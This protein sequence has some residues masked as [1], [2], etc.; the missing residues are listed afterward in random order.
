MG[1]IIKLPEDVANRIAA[2]EVVERP[3]SV[4]KELLENS[5][6][7]DASYIEIVLS[8]GGKNLVLV[9]DDGYGM[10]PDD[11]FLALERHATSKIRCSDDLT[12]I[13]TL[14]FRGEALPSIASVSKLDIISRQRGSDTAFRILVD[15][16][17]IVEQGNVSAQF[18]T[19]VSVK[20]LFAKLPA[21]KRFLKSDTTELS[22]CNAVI[23]RL[24]IA[25]PQTAF[26]VESDGQ[27]SLY[28]TA[29]GTYRERIEQIFGSELLQKCR[30]I[31]YE[32]GEYSV[33]GFV[34]DR[35]LHRSRASDEY[36]FL[37]SRPIR[38]RLI[39]AA[40]HRA[41]SGLLPPRRYPIA[42]IFLQAPPELVDVNVH[43]AKLEVRFRREEAVFG[44]IHRA[45]V[46]AIGSVPSPARTTQPL[47]LS[48]LE[49]TQQTRIDFP[50]PNRPSPGK[51][52]RQPSLMERELA[53]VIDSIGTAAASEIQ[54]DEHTPK[55]L[56]V[57]QSYIVVQ[58]R[59]GMF[60]I[61]QHAA[62]ERVLYE[63]AVA[64]VEHNALSGQR[65][66]FPVEVRL[67]P[68]WIA[69]LAQLV[70]NFAAIGFETEIISN[71]RVLLLSVP[72]FLRGTDYAQLLRSVIE[73][74][75][76]FSP[77]VTDIVK[78]FA[79]TVACHAAIKA[80]QKLSQEEMATLFD[81]LFACDDP[82]HCPHRRPTIVKFTMAQLEKMFGRKS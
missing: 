4:L 37:N 44:A 72:S 64:A 23:T 54:P 69:T 53:D 39:T 77:D 11:M 52:L 41:F 26:R 51:K 36:F 22:R 21:R 9:C 15:N 66:L 2:G 82:F 33:F 1:R 61:D 71:D 12:S 81:S 40:L 38:S 59:D 20:E 58:T 80:G 78:K 13:E 28:L 42:F 79:A 57:H 67:P 49:S 6:D 70:K 3:A 75:S 10:P 73:E 65:L 32:V 30:E 50:Q 31:H 60:I 24:A 35:T 8:A 7:A 25:Y 55:F 19:T 45:V 68:Q 47:I 46:N 29:C 5:L 18:G 48:R 16:G 34:G 63:R 27:E 14:G 76:D 56:Q 74:L 17:E 62:H 43:P